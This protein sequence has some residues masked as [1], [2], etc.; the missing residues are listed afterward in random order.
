[1]SE[2]QVKINGCKENSSAKKLH[3]FNPPSKGVASNA[4]QPCDVMTF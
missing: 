4:L 1:M 3:F 2:S